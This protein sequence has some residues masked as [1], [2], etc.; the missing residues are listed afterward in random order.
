MADDDLKVQILDAALSH[1]PFDG[2]S[3]RT[4]QAAITD[5]AVPQIARAPSAA[6]VGKEKSV[7]PRRTSSRSA[8]SSRVRTAKAIRSRNRSEDRSMAASR[9]AISASPLA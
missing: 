2:W 8:S 3:E 5:A 9:A 7:V 4:L 6:W 1:V